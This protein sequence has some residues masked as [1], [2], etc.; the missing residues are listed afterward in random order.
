[1]DGHDQLGRQRGSESAEIGG[2][3]LE[4]S[5]R[6]VGVGLTQEGNSA[7]EAL[8]QY[9]AERIQIRTP[10]ELLAANLFGRQV[11][12]GAHHDVVAGQIGLGRL[13]P[14]GDAEI[15]EQHPTVGGHHDVARLDVAV[16]E[17]CFVG[18]V[19]C[20][21]D[22]GADVARE[23]GAQPLL[24]VEYLTQTL[25][26]DQLHDHGLASVLFEHVVHGDDVRVVETGRSDRLS[27]EAFG[28]DSIGC[29]RRLEPLD[30]HLAI[31]G[32][33]DRQP[34]F[35]HAALREHAL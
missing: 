18:M 35:G 6:R 33:I 10:V 11:L 26:L 31:E 17:P 12:C 25:A 15:G 30:R 20:G 23:F 16:D 4:P 24:G 2:V 34:H 14:F 27:A 22:T 32:E 7:G 13:Q 28:D 29:E 3:A 19:E 1:M 8:V 21:G 5:E 9:E